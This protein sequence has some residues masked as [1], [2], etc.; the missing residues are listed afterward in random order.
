MEIP[1]TKAQPGFL[2]VFGGRLHG[3]Q[4]FPGMGIYHLAVPRPK[5]GATLARK[6]WT[7]GMRGSIDPVRE[8]RGVTD[9]KL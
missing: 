6:G 5:L 3:E 8:S 7:P 2:D 1:N 4:V 9:A